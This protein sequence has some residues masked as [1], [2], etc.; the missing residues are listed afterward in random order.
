[1]SQSTR[2]KPVDASP[3]GAL[4]PPPDAQKANLPNK[5]VYDRQP[6]E[7]LLQYGGKHCSLWD[8]SIMRCVT[9]PLELIKLPLCSFACDTSKIEYP[10]IQN[11]LY[12]RLW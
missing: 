6:S 3:Y 12:F 8:A 11:Q 2:K 10:R 4:P 5:P 7:V 1:M 9:A